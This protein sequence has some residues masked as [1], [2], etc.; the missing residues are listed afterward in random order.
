MGQETHK[1]ILTG[2]GGSGVVWAGTLIARAG[3]KEYEYAAR[4]PNFTTSMRG[5][6]CECMV[7]LSNDRIA[8]PV[9]SKGDVLL[10]LHNSQLKSY[11]DKVRSD[12][13][14]IL[15]STGL[16]ASV[17]RED[18]RVVEVPAME[19][20]TSMGNPVVSGMIL[21]GAYVQA[22]G[23]FRP[24]FIESELEARWGSGD[25]KTLLADNMGAF[26]RGLEISKAIGS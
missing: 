13:L 15:E 18:V 16:E 23:V 19:M 20:A 4:L 11:E 2:L 17:E 24:E 8:T 6:P 26:G 21:L 12:G 22:T 5:G 3:M 9:V 10:V 14:I 1:V 25:E 7:V